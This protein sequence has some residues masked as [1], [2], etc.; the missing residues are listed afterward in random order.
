MAQYDLG[1][2]GTLVVTPQD[3]LEVAMRR[4]QLEDVLSR[5]QIERD[6]LQLER[7]AG[8]R[9]YQQL[10]QTGEIER[11]RLGEE[12]RYHSGQLEESR[13]DRAARIANEQANL[14]E[15]TK[16]H[17]GSLAEDTRY[18]TGLLGEEK[19]KREAGLVA[20]TMSHFL[21]SEG[22]PGGPAKG[23]TAEIA[24]Q[25]GYPQI[26]AGLAAATKNAAI[27]SAKQNLP[28][29]MGYTPEQREKELGAMA[30]PNVREAL[31]GMLPPPAAT[32][33]P[34]A[35]TTMSR[36][37]FG[38]GA[39]GINFGPLLKNAPI[40]LANYGVAGANAVGIP[41]VNTLNSLFGIPPIPAQKRFPYDY[42]KIMKGQY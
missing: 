10:M 7:E 4:A 21:P 6:R 2:G 15:T 34:T 16:Y 14:A 24:A 37:G 8:Q 36:A 19:A 40:D 32:P 5:P 17:E 20:D 41:A 28:T 23:S 39:P 1:G 31:R 35:G 13:A 29:Y 26:S 11:S 25:F 12:T 9:A 3:P 27:E 22:L 30:D 33:A 38:G 42:S 18:H